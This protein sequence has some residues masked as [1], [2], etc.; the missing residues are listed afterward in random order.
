M[1][2]RRLSGHLPQLDISNDFLNGDLEEEIYMRFSPSYEEL[3]G[4]SVPP[5]VVCR[6]HKSLYG[7]KQAS[8]KY[9]V[10]LETFVCYI[11]DGL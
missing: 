5:N 10:V 3:I 2:Q 4:V 9:Q 1:L 6:L 7:L 8:R 11:A